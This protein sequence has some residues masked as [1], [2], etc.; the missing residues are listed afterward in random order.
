[1]LHTE[2]YNTVQPKQREEHEDSMLDVQDLLSQDVEE[3]LSHINNAVAE[4]ISVKH[5]MAVLP[6]AEDNGVYQ[7]ALQ[8]LEAEIRNRI[9]VMTKQTQH[10]LKILIE[11]LN[12]RL[13]KQQKTQQPMAG[14][15]ETSRAPKVPI[16]IQDKQLS[17]DKLRQLHRQDAVRILELEQKHRLLEIEFKRI[18]DELQLKE[19]ELQT[20]STEI[21][22]ARAAL[23]I[24][25]KEQGE[26]LM[27]NLMKEL[28]FYKAKY[29]GKCKENE[30]LEDKVHTLS[31]LLAADGQPTKSISPQRST[32][33]GRRKRSEG[34]MSSTL[35]ASKLKTARLRT[36]ERSLSNERLKKVYMEVRKHFQ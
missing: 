25:P 12:Y 32:K 8:K 2:F 28:S 13:E 9:T 14:L 17:I 7:K 23:T 21:K 35:T 26:V 18:K 5:R 22:R 11:D 33:A 31:S 34:Q 3:M 19:R 15:E 6:G 20:K 27:A 24:R 4:L 30:A 10:Q 29:E 36:M 16:K 1:M